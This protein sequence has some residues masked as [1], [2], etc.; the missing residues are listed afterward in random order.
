MRLCAS[1]RTKVPTYNSQFASSGCSCSK[2]TGCRHLPLPTL[3]APSLQASRQKGKQASRQAGKL[4][5]RR[6]PKQTKSK[7]LSRHSAC[8]P[9]SSN[10]HY[11]KFLATRG[12]CVPNTGWM[13]AFACAS[14]N[15]ECA[16]LNTLSS[17]SSTASPMSTKPTPRHP[18]PGDERGLRHSSNTAWP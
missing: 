12:H 11:V 2:K 10:A 5:I 9:F 15:I 7:N 18:N 8:H 4:A 1:K 14:S 17:C 6:A 3:P 13:A 16:I